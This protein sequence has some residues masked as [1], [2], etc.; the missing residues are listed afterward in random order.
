MPVGAVIGTRCHAGITGHDGGKPP[1]YIEYDKVTR[2]HRE[3]GPHTERLRKAASDRLH[4]RFEPL[5]YEKPLEMRLAFMGGTVVVSGKADVHVQDLQTEQTGIIDLKFSKEAPQSD[6]LQVSIY[7]WLAN[8]LGIGFAGILWAER[9]GEW[10]CEDFVRPAPDLI[11]AGWIAVSQICKW[12]VAQEEIPRIPSRL[13][14]ST[15]S[16]DCPVRCSEPEGET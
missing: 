2:S 1:D 10:R 9:G 15:C 16:L 7:A 5:E 8:E 4:A 12:A 3:L 6:W 13:A 11:H 14:C